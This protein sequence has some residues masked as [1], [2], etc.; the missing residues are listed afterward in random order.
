MG[1]RRRPDDVTA[2]RA[3]RR[4]VDRHA[5][6]FAATGLPPAATASCADWDE[7]LMHGFV[8]GDPQAFEVDQL[9]EAQYA[10]LVRLAGEYFV[11]YPGFY[12]PMALRRID[13]DA[14]RHRFV[15]PAR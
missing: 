13:Q 4:F 10:P 6:V 7:F 11:E 12:T 1:F 14:L 15:G 8:A 9:T 2:G 5:A 3:W